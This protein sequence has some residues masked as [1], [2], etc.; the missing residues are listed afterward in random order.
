MKDFKT[1]LNKLK[2]IIAPQRKVLDKEVASALNIKPTTLASYKYRD[3]AP[4]KAILTYLKNRTNQSISR[5][6]LLYLPAFYFSYC[7]LLQ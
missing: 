7:S 2:Q 6:S 4:Y 3:K 1:I 5:G